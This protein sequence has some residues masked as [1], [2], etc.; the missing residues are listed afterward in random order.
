MANPSRLTVR[1]FAPRPIDRLAQRAFAER[2]SQ[3][4][5]GEGPCLCPEHRDAIEARNDNDK[6]GTSGCPAWLAYGCAALPCWRC[7]RPRHHAR[8]RVYAV[9]SSSGSDIA[10]PAW[11]NSANPF[12]R[13]CSQWSTNTAGS[14]GAGE[15]G[16]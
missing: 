5:L 7:V 1:S 4:M 15:R 11:R 6:A 2:P 14:D 16:G 8:D 9:A 3:E 13:N 12:T 10:T